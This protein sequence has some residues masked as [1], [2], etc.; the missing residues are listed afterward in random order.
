[1]KGNMGNLNVEEVDTD[2]KK[3]LFCE[4]DADS[5]DHEQN[6]CSQELADEEAQID[7]GLVSVIIPVYNVEKYL[8][9]CIQ[10]VLNQS[11]PYFEL[12]LIDDGS[13]DNSSEICDE[14]AQT[15]SRIRV[16]HKE[17]Q[18]VSASR[19][20][21]IDEA[22]GD[23]IVFVDSDDL[24]QKR[25]LQK[26]VRAMTCYQTDLA[27]CGYERFR[28]KWQ[29]RHRLSPYSL[30]IMQSKLE[31]AS[32]YKTPA[33]NMFG[34]SIWA[35]MYRA[36]LIREQNI[37]FHEDINYEEDCVFN[38]DYFR[39]VTTTAVLRDY[40]YRYRQLDVSLSKGYRK[41]SFRFLVNG[42]R[43]RRAFLQELG[44][45]SQ[46]ADN[47]FM[48]VV[49][50]T[51]IKIFDSNLPKN[52]KLAEYLSIAEF[53]ESQNVCRIGTHSKSRLT[54]YLAEAVVSQNVKKIHQTIFIWKQV[55]R[56]KEI[57]KKILKKVLWR[58]KR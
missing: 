52:E 13:T 28:D 26:M 40:F 6:N 43:E 38:L 54:R 31:L 7:R 57:I 19:N 4:Q 20:K 11:Y 35:K 12:I 5:C 34:V 55:V 56:S 15:D 51:L 21:G 50:T 30:V 16:I 2:S 42:Y 45:D 10:S 8:P 22:K 25:M 47:I 17:N 44:M 37:R 3:M 33:T 49:K 41:D 32:V 48:I 36:D 39:Y 18:G 46:G 23:F 29:Q 14:F 24:I 9:W 53:E 1:M 27:I 58:G